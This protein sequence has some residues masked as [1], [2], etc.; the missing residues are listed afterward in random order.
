[1]PKKKERKPDI[2]KNLKLHFILTATLS[3]AAVLLVAF[4]TIYFIVSQNI[5]HRPPIRIEFEQPETQNDTQT[6][7]SQQAQDY[8]E[9]RL[10][11]DR[12]A[13]LKI[14][15]T[16][17]ITTGIVIEA[18]VALISIHLAEQAI[19]PVREAYEAQKSFIANASHEIKTPLAVIQANL[20][21]ADI[22]DNHWIDNVAKKTEDLARLNQQLLALAKMDIVEQEPTLKKTNIYNVVQE[23]ADFYKP[24]A[25]EKGINTSIISKN[26]KI[27]KLTNRPDLEQL[28]NILLDNA[29]KYGKTK[30]DIKL[31]DNDTIS[32]SNDGTTIDQKDLKHIFDRFYQSDK[33]KSGVGLGLAIAK[34]IATNNKWSLTAKSSDKVTTFTLKI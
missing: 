13:S 11:D 26:T 20:E 25:N 5:N 27:V 28:L 32:I 15:L 17:L 14:L 19:R 34:Q 16:S 22:K 6:Q 21:A 7:T 10:K 1:M 29:V 24:K 2:F 8:F 18:I 31:S 4:S 12:D 3:S 9:V 33:T 30:I 23:T